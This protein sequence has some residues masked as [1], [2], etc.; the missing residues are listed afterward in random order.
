MAG[1]QVIIQEHCLIHHTARIGNG[2]EICMG[3][4]ILEGAQ[5]GKNCTIRMSVFLG[6]RVC[7][8]DGTQIHPHAAL[9]ND[10]H[11]GKG[12][13]IGPS[14]SCT[15]I[16]YPNVAHKEQEVLCPPRI[17]DGAIIGAN[18]VLLAGVVI[19]AGAVV[20]AGSVVTH[21]VPPGVVVA[22]NPARRLLK[23]QRRR[24]VLMNE[25]G[26]VADG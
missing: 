21:D 10:M 26:E 9:P 15:N 19:G 24:L 8:G 3:T 17:E 4:T 14:V 1:Y 13:Y 7:I 6:R 11:V 23:A 18:A 16:K 5:I 12:V 2:T 22:G 25:A 20:G